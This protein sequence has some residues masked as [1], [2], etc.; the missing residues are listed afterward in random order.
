MSKEQE[1]YL[2]L[3]VYLSLSYSEKFSREEKEAA[4]VCQNENNDAHCFCLFQFNSDE[5]EVCYTLHLKTDINVSK[6]P[7]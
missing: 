3:V 6:W 4:I 2:A 7:A 1:F 5:L